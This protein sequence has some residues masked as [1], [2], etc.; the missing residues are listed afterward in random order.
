[1]LASCD[2]HL[3]RSNAA[4]AS[5]RYTIIKMPLTCSMTARFAAISATASLMNRLALLGRERHVD[6]ET[7]CADHFAALVTKQVGDHDDLMDAPLD[8]DDAV[9]G[10]ER[11]MRSTDVVQC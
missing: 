4:S 6:I 8:I 2:R 10:A 11:P 5:T 1:M 9:A 3:R 7:V